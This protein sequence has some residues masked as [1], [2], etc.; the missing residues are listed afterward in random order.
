MIFDHVNFFG[1]DIIISVNLF[2][3]IDYLLI[4]DFPFTISIIRTI[5]SS[6][7]APGCVVAL[8]PLPG[9][10]GTGGT[11]LPAA[12]GVALCAGVCW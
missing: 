12:V 7:P 4:F 6:S 9:L 1:I 2:F 3:I 10:A 11:R 8:P 5:K